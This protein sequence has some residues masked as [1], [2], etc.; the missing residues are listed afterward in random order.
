MMMMKMMI[1]AMVVVMMVKTV[2]VLTLVVMKL[3]HGGYDVMMMWLT[4]SGNGDTDHGDKRMAKL[5]L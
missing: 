1:V 2:F 4:D 3:V 5:F